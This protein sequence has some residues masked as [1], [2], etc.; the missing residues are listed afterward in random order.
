[1]PRT[2][3]KKWHVVFSPSSLLMHT[4][5]RCTFGCACVIVLGSF[6]FSC[7]QKDKDEN[8]ERDIEIE[9]CEIEN[10]RNKTNRKRKWIRRAEDDEGLS[11]PGIPILGFACC[12]GHCLPSFCDFIST[13]TKITII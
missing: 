8:E 5:C 13:T 2:K 6:L 4:C 3:E 10:G 9:M 1:M 11:G 7:R 12:C